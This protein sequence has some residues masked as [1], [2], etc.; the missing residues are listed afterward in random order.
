VPS[1]A[2]FW[3]TVTYTLFETYK[4]WCQLNVRRSELTTAVRMSLT[5]A[6]KNHDINLVAEAWV[7]D[8]L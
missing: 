7:M 5:E 3:G 1:I 8:N 6:E 4:K 2:C